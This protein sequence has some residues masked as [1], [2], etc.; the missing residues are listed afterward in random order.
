[1]V[2][3]EPVPS[4]PRPEGSRAGPPAGI[5]PL[6][7]LTGWE[8]EY[9]TR[10]QH[11]ANTARTCNDVLARC[12]V[13]PGSEPDERVR[14]RVRTLLV[15]ERDLELVRLR[16]MSIGPQ[17][18]ARVECPSC[19]AVNDADFSLDDLDLEPG[20]PVE[21]TGLPVGDDELTLTLPTAGD[22]EELLDA[23]LDDLAERRT[24]L[25]ARSLRRPDGSPLGLDA[26]RELP[27][28][29][30]AELER[31]VDLL[32]PTL[33]LTMEVSCADCGA[34]F[35]APFDVG[36]FFF[37]ADW[38][39]RRPAQGRTPNRHHLPLVRAAGLGPP[40]PPPAGLPARARGGGRRRSLRG[41]RH[42]GR[43]RAAELTAVAGPDVRPGP[44]CTSGLAG[45]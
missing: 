43:P 36:S 28:R 13:A 3:S 39:G 45:R 44:T 31:S 30:R 14:A 34:D 26:A 35:T 42:G 2:A 25:L 37:R 22:Q 10:H 33:D 4:P 32:L 6:R 24:W 38:A 16:R 27:L 1:M 9:L 5:L 15:A 23:G 8:E 19:G 21:R 12:C 7:E 11:D 18:Q 41:S 20:F 17:V 40:A 29:R